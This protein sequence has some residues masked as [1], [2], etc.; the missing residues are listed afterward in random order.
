METTKPK[1]NILIGVDVQND[2]VSGSLAVNGG[3]QV[4]TP[5]NNMARD[6]RDSGGTVIWTRDWHPAQTPHFEQWPVHCVAGTEG[7]DFHSRL[8]VRDQDIIISKGTGETDGYSGFEGFDPQGRNLDQ[9]ATERRNQRNRYF[10]GGLATDYC[11]K[12]TALDLAQATAGMPRTE[13]YLI[14]DAVRG[15]NLEANDEAKALRAI[16]DAGF[17]AMTSQEIRQLFFTPDKVRR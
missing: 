9:L 12:A 4:V 3:E 13:L 14:R 5:L 11:V 16:E 6:V 7:A 8:D 1:R 2:F 15:V 17:V 10:I